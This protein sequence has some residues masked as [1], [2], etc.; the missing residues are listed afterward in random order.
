MASYPARFFARTQ[1]GLCTFVGETSFGFSLT[2]QY[3][4]VIL[5]Y[6]MVRVTKNLGWR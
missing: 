1:R 3:I 5:D 4:D 2:I 6:V